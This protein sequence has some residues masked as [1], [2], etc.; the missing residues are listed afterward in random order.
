MVKME[1]RQR[2]LNNGT[3]VILKIVTHENFSDI[4]ENLNL[5]TERAH[6]VPRKL[7]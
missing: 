1:A 3:E 6:Q 7:S 5:Q 4:K 2:G